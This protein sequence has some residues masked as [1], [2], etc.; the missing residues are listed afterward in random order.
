MKQFFII[1]LAVFI[2]LLNISASADQYVRGYTRSN[3][4]YVQPYHRSSP[5]NS[6]RD[7]FSYKGNANPYNG[8]VGSNRYIHDKTSPYYQGPDSHG[9]VG[10]SGSPGSYEVPI[11]N[12]VREIP[13]PYRVQEI[14]LR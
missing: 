2:V 1:F 4:T 3:G 12:R 6:A 7:N 8:A 14:P 10:H 9:R 5:N 13:L 11:P